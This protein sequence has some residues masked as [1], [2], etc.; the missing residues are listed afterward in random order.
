MGLVR[1]RLWTKTGLTFVAIAVVASIARGAPAT[2]PQRISL[3]VEGKTVDLLKFPSRRLTIS[4][5]CASTGGTLACDAFKAWPK[6]TLDGIKDQDLR[7]GANPGA[8]VC[9]Q[10]LRGKIVVGRFEDGSELSLCRF[11]DGSLLGTGS[12]LFAAN[13]PGEAK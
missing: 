12:I 4:A 7:G 11:H 2:E 6:S 8:V 1:G 9:A 10:V 13:N 5:S 3:S